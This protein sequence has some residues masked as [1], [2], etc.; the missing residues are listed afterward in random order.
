MLTFPSLALGLIIALLIG[1]LFHLWQGGGGERLWL[2]L[3]LSVV[4][5]GAGHLLGVRA[6]WILIPVGPLDLGMA[7][8]GSLLLLGLGHWLARLGQSHPSG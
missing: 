4:G 8:M 1:A 6:H 3:V 2:Y 7:V 5:F